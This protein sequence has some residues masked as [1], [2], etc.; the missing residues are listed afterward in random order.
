MDW[1][2]IKRDYRPGTFTLREMAAKHETD[3]ATI[4]RKIKADRLVDPDAW[5]RDLTAAVRAATNAKLMQAMVTNTVTSGQ[6][7]V[8]NVILAAAEVNSQVI[9]RHRLKLAEVTAAAD[10]AK[11][12]VL[13]L[14][15]TV[16]DIREAATAMGAIEAWSRITKTVVDKEREAFNLD[17]AP[18]PPDTP[19]TQDWASK[20]AAD[21]MAAYLRMVHGQ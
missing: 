5:P 11:T 7:E 6:Q 9:L 12:K 18:P 1:D 13:S 19:A 8:T 2:A 21:G 16:A 14:L 10:A 17:D 20:S 4:A 15:D 3:H